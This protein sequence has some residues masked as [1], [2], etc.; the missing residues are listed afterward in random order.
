M[1]VDVTIKVP[2]EWMDA[3]DRLEAE[4]VQVAVIGRPRRSEEAAQEFL[5]KARQLLVQF[6]LDLPPELSHLSLNPDALAELRRIILA[7]MRDAAARA[8]Q[9]KRSEVTAEDVKPVGSR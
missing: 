9:A 2:Q 6:K 5:E 3:A 7:I 4:G 8:S 1:E